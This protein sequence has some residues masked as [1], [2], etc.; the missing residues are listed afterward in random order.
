[1]S[2]FLIEERTD[3]FIRTLFFY[4]QTSYRF[5]S[6][7]LLDSYV[8]PRYLFSSNFRICL[9]SLIHPFLMSTLFVD[10]YLIEFRLVLHPHS[11]LLVLIH[12]STQPL[13]SDKVVHVAGRSA[14]FFSDFLI[15]SRPNDSFPDSITKVR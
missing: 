9:Q 6:A 8:L 12:L 3:F 14:C 4:L 11:I 5:M 2:Y 13:Q 10:H 1:M 7:S 15:S